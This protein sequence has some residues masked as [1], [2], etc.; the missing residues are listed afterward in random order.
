MK[1]HC[2]KIDLRYFT[3]ESLSAGL[4][5]LIIS[6]SSNKVIH[7]SIDWS[8]I[9]DLDHS[10]KNYL[11]GISRCSHHNVKMVLSVSSSAYYTHI[12]NQ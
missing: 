7:L 5:Q 3:K 12:L 4:I 10:T 11:L 2:N 8:E 6:F 1:L 9:A